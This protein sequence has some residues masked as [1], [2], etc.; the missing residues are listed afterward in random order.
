MKLSALFLFGL[1]ASGPNVRAAEYTTVSPQNLFR[2]LLKQAKLVKI[3]NDSETGNDYVV[4]H[5]NSVKTE[6]TGA[7][8]VASK[9]EGRNSRVEFFTQKVAGSL[10]SYGT[11]TSE[12]IEYHW[13]PPYIGEHNP[14]LFFEEHPTW[15]DAKTL[16]VDVEIDSVIKNNRQVRLIKKAWFT[17]LLER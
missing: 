10:I 17:E 3:E 12:V 8:G 9:P 11:M 14:R 6:G 4:L 16:A 1:L 7:V 15:E 2:V 5:F 13:Y